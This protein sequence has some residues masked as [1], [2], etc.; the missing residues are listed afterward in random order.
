[1]SIIKFDKVD[2]IFSRIR[3]KPSSCWTKASRVTRF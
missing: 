2:V 3:V 1:M